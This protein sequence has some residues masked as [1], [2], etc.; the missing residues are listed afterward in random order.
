MRLSALVPGPVKRMWRSS[1]VRYLVVGGVAFLF[2][3]GLLFVLHDLVHI[4]LVIATPVAFFTSF[5]LTFVMQ[6]SITFQTGAGWRSSAVKYTALVVFNAFA[7]TAI[8]TGIDALGWPWAVGKGIAVASTTVWN[9]FGYRYWIFPAAR[10][11]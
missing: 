10:S 4:D 1:A 5:A 7:T 9:Y 6:R 8:V 2:D 11:E 3:F